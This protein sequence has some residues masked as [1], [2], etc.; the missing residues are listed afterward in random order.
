MRDYRKIRLPFPFTQRVNG[1]DS[2][3][4]YNCRG[5]LEDLYLSQVLARA[6]IV[7]HPK[8]CNR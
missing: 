8:L 7:S 1:S 4:S 6:S 5:Y 3:V 2:V